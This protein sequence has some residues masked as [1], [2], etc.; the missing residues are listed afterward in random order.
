[1]FTLGETVTNYEGETGTVLT[2]GRVYEGTQP[3][4]VTVIT[5]PGGK[6]ER[7]RQAA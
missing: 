1:M 5:Y 6:V 2:I 4:T 3:F 7:I